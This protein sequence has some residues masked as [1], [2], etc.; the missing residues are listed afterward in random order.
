MTAPKTLVYIGD[1]LLPIS[2]E[3]IN[4]KAQ[5]QNKTFK[6]ANGEEINQVLPPGLSEITME[7]V[8]LPNEAY[9]FCQP[10]SAGEIYSAAFLL[11][12]FGTLK[13]E[14]RAFPLIINNSSDG[15]CNDGNNEDG[16]YTL[17]NYT[18]QRSIDLNM[19]Y[20]ATLTFK[21]YVDYGVQT[22]ALASA[23]NT[24]VNSI[25][26]M[27]SAASKTVKKKQKRATTKS[28]TTEQTY[29]VKSGDTLWAISKSFYGDGSLYPYLANLNG[30]KNANVI[31]VGQVLRIGPKEDA[32]KYKNKSA[33]TTSSSSSSSRLTSGGSAKITKETKVQITNTTGKVVGSGATGKL[34]KFEKAI[35]DGID[36]NSNKTTETVVIKDY[37]GRD[38]IIGGK[39]L[40]YEKEIENKET[41]TYIDKDKRTSTSGREYNGSGRSF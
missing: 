15:L 13:K 27:I 2:P 4:Y 7:K 31:T 28:S 6:L 8:L 34:N 21:E 36:Q 3:R 19:D 33:G 14:K 38:V 41:S 16:L 35:Q 9:A 12:L 32:E 11:K 17:E 1:V 5:N 29:T 39:S 10:N 20:E 18:V 22:V 25:G 26:T 24:L 40:T 23:V 37:L 30:L